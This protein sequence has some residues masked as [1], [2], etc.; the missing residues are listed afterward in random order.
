MFKWIKRKILIIKGLRADLSEKETLLIKHNVY[1]K[2]RRLREKQ[3]L[4]NKNN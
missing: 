3:E 2:D 4:R 1:E